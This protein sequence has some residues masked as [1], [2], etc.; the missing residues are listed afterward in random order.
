MQV[1]AQFYCKM[2][3]GQLGAKSM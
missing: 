3:G 1:W 2:W